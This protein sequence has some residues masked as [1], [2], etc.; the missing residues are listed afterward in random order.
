MIDQ[1]L[2]NFISDRKIVLVNTD[3]TFLPF[4][5][6]IVVRFNN[7]FPVLQTKETTDILVLNEPLSKEEIQDNYAPRFILWCPPKYDTLTKYLREVSYYLPQETYL[8]LCKAVKGVP[9]IELLT[10]TYLY[11]YTQQIDLTYFKLT[12]S[13]INENLFLKFITKTPD[14]NY[15]IPENIQ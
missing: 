6:N 8:Q 5:D 14:I 2:Y 4:N 1:A 15:S 3:I 9:S 12:S 10:L 11:T 7:Q 13:N